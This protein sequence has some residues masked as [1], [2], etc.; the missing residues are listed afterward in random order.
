[1]RERRVSGMRAFVAAAVIIAV[2][3]PVAVMANW[4]VKV[5]RAKESDVERLA[6]DWRVFMAEKQRIREVMLQVSATLRQR[7]LLGGD[8]E[9][10][11]S[12]QE[13]FAEAQE[14][15]ISNVLA[16]MQR[17]ALNPAAS[18]A[19]AQLIMTELLLV[20]KQEQMV[21]LDG[22]EE[23]QRFHDATE[24]MVA[25]RCED[26]ALDECVSTGRF[27]QILDLVFAAGRQSQ[28]LGRDDSIEEWAEDA[29]KQCAIYELHFVSTTK[30]GMMPM[31]IETVRDGRIKIRYQP[32]PGGLLKSAASPE[33]LFK[34]ETTGGNNPFFVAVKCTSPAPNMEFICSPA[35]DSTPITVRLKEMD[36]KHPEFYVETEQLKKP[37]VKSKILVTEKIVA[38][39]RLVGENKLAFEFEGGMFSLKGMIKAPYNTASIPFPD[40]GNTFYM[41]HKKDM[42]GGERSG[43]LL[44]R[45]D[46]LGVEPALFDFVYADQNTYANATVTDST[47]FELIHKPEPKPFRNYEPD[48]IR[49]PLR[50]RPN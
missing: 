27:Q 34:G 5:G 31:G 33:E 22:S 46:H 10:G 38:K 19:E 25:L 28:L 43:K 13:L 21:G 41:A 49:K 26:E 35:A 50:P 29:L 11:M 1:M 14:K 9:P 8:A 17:I 30:G 40:W 12:P 48:P 39:S 23:I 20:R 32:P 2:G 16:P 4:G 36:L 18:C 47:Q 6:E 24:R 42:I 15:W 44:I 45:S 3:C 37:D 7:Q